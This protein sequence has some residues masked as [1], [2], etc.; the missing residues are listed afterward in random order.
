MWATGFVISEVAV[1]GKSEQSVSL[2]TV[3]G[4]TG[5]SNFFY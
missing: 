2:H 3:F 5:G 1:D 4:A